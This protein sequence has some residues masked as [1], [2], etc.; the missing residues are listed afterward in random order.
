MSA[1]ETPLEIAKNKLQFNEV[2]S[3]MNVKQ[4]VYEKALGVSVS[5]EAVGIIAADIPGGAAESRGHVALI[6]DLV[7]AH[8]HARGEEVYEVVSGAGTLYWGEVEKDRDGAYKIDT[9][10]EYVISAATPVDVVKSDSF[11]IPEG[12]AHQLVS[13]GEEPL[14]ITFQCPDSHLKDGNNSRDHEDRTVIPQLAP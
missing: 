2:A 6:P 5:D 9:N 12:Y 11:I 10:G 3:Q 7:G 14:V 8:F 4:E 13:T 1:Q